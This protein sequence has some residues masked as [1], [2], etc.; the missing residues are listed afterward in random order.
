[1]RG[2]RVENPDAIEVP[3]LLARQSC[4]IRAGISIVSMP[5]GGSFSFSI[6]LNFEISTAL[7]VMTRSSV[8][9][10]WRAAALLLD[11]S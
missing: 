1:M 10:C 3:T 9:R 11:V 8:L 2:E 5:G 4:P 7:A 6:T